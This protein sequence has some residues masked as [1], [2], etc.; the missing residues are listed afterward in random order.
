M[1]NEKKGK[2]LID[3]REERGWMIIN[4]DKGEDGWT[5]VGGNGTSVIVITN[6]KE[7]AREEVEMIKEGNKTELAVESRNKGCGNRKERKEETR[8]IY[9]KEGLW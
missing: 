4:R 1:K 3:N 7:K 2:I 6:E 9:R 5:Y 8:N